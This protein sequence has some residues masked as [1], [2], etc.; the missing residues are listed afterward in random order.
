[1]LPAECQLLGR[2]LGDERD[3]AAELCEPARE[4]QGER[5][6]VRMPE[7]GGLSQGFPA[8][9]PGAIGEAGHPVAP[10][11][12]GGHAW[13]LP[14]PCRGGVA[15]GEREGA[16]QMLPRALELAQVKARLPA[17]GVGPGQQPCIAASPGTL[18]NLPGQRARRR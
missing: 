9:R 10:A 17:G 3:L 2:P 1:M 8:E 14:A 16:A 11:R 18:E 15:A 7:G 6:V 4:P 12:I 13:I 5:A